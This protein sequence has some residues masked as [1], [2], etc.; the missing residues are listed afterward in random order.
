MSDDN[1]ISFMEQQCQISSNYTSILLQPSSR[2]ALTWSDSNMRYLLPQSNNYG[3]IIWH[4]SSRE[5]L[6]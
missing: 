5:A 2:E 4:P 6:T 3:A 1:D